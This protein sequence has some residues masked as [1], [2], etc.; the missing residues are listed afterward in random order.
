M[1]LGRSLV[2]VQPLLTTRISL[3]LCRAVKSPRIPG[4]TIEAARVRRHW[5]IGHRIVR[6]V[7][8][9]GF[10]HHGNQRRA[11][12]GSCGK[13]G[14]TT[15]TNPRSPTEPTSDYG[16][17][18]SAP[19]WFSSFTRRGF[20]YEY[21]HIYRQIYRFVAIYERSLM[22]KIKTANQSLSRQRCQ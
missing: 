8:G 18:S 20:L 14:M 19:P 22:P 3:I 2:Q 12:V 5:D 15:P 11:H 9:N 6:L 16:L 7:W 13:F 10:S 17:I 1:T 4:A 21:V